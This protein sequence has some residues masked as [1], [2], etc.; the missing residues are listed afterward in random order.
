MSEAMPVSSSSRR[1]PMFPLSGVVF[2][3]DQLPLNVFEPRYQRLVTD[4]QRGDGEFGIVLIA[5]GSEV[6]GGDERFAVGT[7]SRIELANPYSGGRWFLLVRGERRIRVTA[8]LEDDPYPLAEVDE[9]P[10]IRWPK[11]EEQLPAVEASVARTLALL[12]ELSGGEPRAFDRPEDPLE[13]LWKLAS[14]APLNPIDAQKVLETEDPSDRADL[15]LGLVDSFYEDL[16]HLREQ[17]R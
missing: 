2:P 17:E 8:W 5:R 4:C 14:I 11:A 3:T 16:S 9:L 15:L 13:L 1:L 7:L 10:A 6:G 12:A